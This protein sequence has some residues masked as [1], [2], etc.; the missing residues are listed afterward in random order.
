VRFVPNVLMKFLQPA[1]AAIGA[2]SGAARDGS[3]DVAFAED[4]GH[5]QAASPRTYVGKRRPHGGAKHAS[6]A[7]RGVRYIGSHYRST[8]SQS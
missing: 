7:R 8:R 4:R 1:A 3:G 2:T 6:V 5:A